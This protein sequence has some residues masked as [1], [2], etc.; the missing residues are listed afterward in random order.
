MKLQRGIPAH[1]LTIEF[2]WCKKDFL[3]M[4]PGYRAARSKMHNP[5]D[6][7]FWC[8]HAFDDGEMM[9]LAQPKGKGGNKMLCQKCATELMEGE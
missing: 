5:M 1:T 3:L 2:N 9:A 6:S 7:C 4:S 8:K